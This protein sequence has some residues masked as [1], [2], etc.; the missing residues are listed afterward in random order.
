MT[1]REW[2]LS[3]KDVCSELNETGQSSYSSSAKDT[4]LIQFVVR[5]LQKKTILAVPMQ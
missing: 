2:Q 5:W 1:P 3:V 4:D